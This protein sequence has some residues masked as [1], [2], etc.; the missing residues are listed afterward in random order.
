MQVLAEDAD[1]LAGHAVGHHRAVV[2]HHD[3]VADLA[4]QVGAVGDEQDRLALLLDLLDAVEALLLEDLVADGEH[5]VDQQDVG[6][7][8]DG[9]G[10]A[11]P[12]V[13][14]R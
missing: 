5:L 1:R 8:V 4:G 10:E 7:D 12:H 14:A 11:Q 13:H 3:P 6:V 9:H 2:E